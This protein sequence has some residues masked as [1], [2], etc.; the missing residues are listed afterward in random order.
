MILNN[1][2]FSKIFFSFIFFIII[3]GGYCK[4]FSVTS[5]DFSHYKCT[6]KKKKRR[7]TRTEG[8]SSCGRRWKWEV[9]NMAADMSAENVPIPHPVAMLKLLLCFENSYSL[10]LVLKCW[11]RGLYSQEADCWGFLFSIA[12][13]ENS[14]T[15]QLWFICSDNID[16]NENIFSLSVFAETFVVKWSD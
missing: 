11:T 9:T 10:R 5:C 15:S 16:P 6:R 3:I 2:N 12:K 13:F 7:I 14:F 1:I 4:L 8:S